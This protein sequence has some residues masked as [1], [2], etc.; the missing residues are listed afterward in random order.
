MSVILLPYVYSFMEKK[1]KKYAFSMKYTKSTFT[2]R[3]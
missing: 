3:V 2:M 1:E